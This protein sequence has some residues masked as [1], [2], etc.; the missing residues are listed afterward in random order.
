M[1][2]AN[3]VLMGASISVVILLS[4]ETGFTILPLILAI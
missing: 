4:I 2:V 1:F 3:T